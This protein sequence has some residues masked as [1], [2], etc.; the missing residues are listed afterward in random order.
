MAHGSYARTVLE[1]ALELAAA[2]S[3]EVTSGD[4]SSALF[5]QTR[6]AHK[7]LLNTLSE[8]SRTGKLRRVSQGTYAPPIV[9]MAKQ[10]TK[11]Q[12]MWNLI[13]MRKRVTVEDLVELGEVSHDYAIECLRILVRRGYVRKIQQPGKI[14]VWIALCDTVK[15]PVNDENAARL[16][17]LRRQKKEAI[18]GRLDAIDT[19]LI[20][21]RQILSTLEDE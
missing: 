17:E 11:W 21:V 16:R 9:G 4:I 20:D 2:K 18:T 12:R 7:R 3:G 15:A 1:K 10:P 14:G 19:A 13:K 8:L 6:L 5:I